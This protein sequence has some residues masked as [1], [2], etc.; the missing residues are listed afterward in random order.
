MFVEAFEHFADRTIGPANSAVCGATSRHPVSFQPDVRRRRAG[1]ANLNTH[2]R[3]DCE[4][5][6]KSREAAVP[7]RLNAID[8]CGNVVHSGVFL[9]LT[10]DTSKLGKSMVPKKIFFT[11]GVGQTQGAADLV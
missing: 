10:E 9:R 6:M 11:K 7:G 3:T 2:S 8:S 5:R 1:R 4:R